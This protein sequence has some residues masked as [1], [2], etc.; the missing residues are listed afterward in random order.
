MQ[1]RK[2]KKIDVPQFQVFEFI[3]TTALEAAITNSKKDSEEACFSCMATIH[4]PKNGEH[5]FS[6]CN[7]AEMLRI[8]KTKNSAM[9]K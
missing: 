3:S 2:K 1:K 4:G 8:R 5:C 7:T 6:N 9:M